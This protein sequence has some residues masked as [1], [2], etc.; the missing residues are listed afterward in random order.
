MRNNFDELFILK[1][2]KMNDSKFINFNQNVNLANSK[3][4]ELFF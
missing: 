4:S 2:Y 3:I 1:I